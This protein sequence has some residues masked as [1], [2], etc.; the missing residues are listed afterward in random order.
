MNSMPKILL[1][2]DPLPVEVGHNFETAGFPTVRQAM[3]GGDPEAFRQAQL[4]V[5]MPTDAQLPHAQALCRR[6]RIELGEQYVPILWLQ[7]SN[8]LMSHGLDAGADA[9][10]PRSVPADYLLA[11]ARAL[12]RTQHVHERLL[13]R[14]KEANQ[15]NHRLRVSGRRYCRHSRL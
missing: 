9:C 5:L 2:G 11:Q 7:E 14:S 6:W 10:L 12:L 15:I 3:A 1:V 4:I 13:V 8:R